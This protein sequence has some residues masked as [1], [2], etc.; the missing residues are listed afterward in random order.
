[1][2]ICVDNHFNIDDQPERKQ[3]YYESYCDTVRL[4]ITILF[5]HAYQ[6]IVQ[7]SEF[8]EYLCSTGR[9]ADAVLKA[10]PTFDNVQKNTLSDPDALIAEVV[11]CNTV[12]MHYM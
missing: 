3:I 2:D 5:S 9:I 11:I 8:L 10:L 4:P 12:C 1:M 7:V 6:F